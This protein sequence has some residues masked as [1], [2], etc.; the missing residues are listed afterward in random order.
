MHGSKF[1]HF[2]TGFGDQG[3]VLPFVAAVAIALVAAGARREALYWC[4]AMVVALSA[5][6]ALKLFFL[7]CGHLFPWLSLHSP[8]GHAAAS[9]A[10]YG[11]FALLWAKLTRDRWLRVAF[12]ASAFLFAIG[13]ATSRVL[14]HVHTV[15]EVLL[16]GLMG[17]S[18][19]AVLSRVERRMDEP[20]PRPLSLLLLLPLILVLLLHGASLPVEGKIQTFAA[21][22]ADTLGICL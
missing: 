12:I 18:A 5:T 6:L 1:L 2:V 21:W 9:I 8:S 11:G 7:P 14:I 13:I 15:P 16:G 10:A 19:P 4:A 3:V 20:T 17:L 22:A